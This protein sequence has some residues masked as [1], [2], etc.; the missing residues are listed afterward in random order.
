MRRLLFPA[1][2]SKLIIGKRGRS[3]SHHRNFEDKIAGQPLQDCPR[4]ENSLDL[5]LE[6]LQ[7][8]RVETNNNLADFKKEMAYYLEN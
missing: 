8:G 1:K 6:D 4:L 3:M 5:A 2:Y 7:A